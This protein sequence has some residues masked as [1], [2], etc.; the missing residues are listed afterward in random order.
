MKTFSKEYNAIAIDT[1]KNMINEDKMCGYEINEETTQYIKRFI[2]AMASSLYELNQ[3][4]SYVSDSKIRSAIDKTY[5]TIA[6][7]R[8]LVDNNMIDSIIEEM[9]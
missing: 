5:L 7:L 3:L 4:S 9:Q 6:G 2:N 8:E 1:V